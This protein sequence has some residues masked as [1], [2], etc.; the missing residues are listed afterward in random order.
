MTEIEAGG[1]SFPTSTMVLKN[2]LYVR[3]TDAVRQSFIP[4]ARERKRF[5]VRADILR[6]EAT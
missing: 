6:T 3:I 4:G 2:R 1:G 5:E